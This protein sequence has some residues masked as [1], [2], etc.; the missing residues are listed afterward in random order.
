MKPFYWVALALLG[1]TSLSSA[2]FY[3]L[4]LGSNEPVPLARA[5]NLFHWSKVVLLGS[6]N[7]W[8][9]GRVIDAIRAIP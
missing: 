6:F 7:I 4:Y 9:F 1:L 2:F 3:V 5:R 8:I